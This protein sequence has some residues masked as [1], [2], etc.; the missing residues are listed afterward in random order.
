MPCNTSSL[1]DPCI[2]QPLSFTYPL[3]P[4]EAFFGFKIPADAI[5]HAFI[6][7]FIFFHY[8]NC[9][10]KTRQGEK[11]RKEKMSTPRSRCEGDT[12]RTGFY[13]KVIV[14][15]NCGQWIVTAV[16]SEV[17]SCLGRGLGRASSSCCNG[18]TAVIA[19]LSPQ[20]PIITPGIQW[21]E[22][23]TLPSDPFD[24]GRLGCYSVVCK[25]REEETCMCKSCSVF[26]IQSKCRE[27]ARAHREQR[28]V[29]IRLQQPLQ[30]H[31]YI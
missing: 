18:S 12:C 20:L 2:L 30:R 25:F 24:H 16:G 4:P 7:V 5:N 6:S 9:S 13:K 28:V 19:L 11:T 21:R 14:L 3:T 23:K 27:A 15:L 10:F 29:S 26:Q 31:K 1:W 17:R 22:Q 8:N